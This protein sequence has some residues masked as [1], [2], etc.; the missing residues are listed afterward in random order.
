MDGLNEFWACFWRMSWQS[1]MLAVLVMGIDFLLRRRIS[2]GWRCALWLLVAARLVMPVLPASSVS[3]FNLFQNQVTPTALTPSRGQT[4]VTI[5]YGPISSP[6][7]ATPVKAQEQNW[8]WTALVATALWMAGALMLLGRRVRAERRTA[9]ML[10]AMAAFSEPRVLELVE[11][12]RLEIGLWRSVFV[13]SSNHVRT[14]AV[15]G[16]WRATLILPADISISDVE[17][18]MVVLHELAHVKRFDL[19]MDRVLGILRDLHWFNPAAWLLLRSWREEREMAC[20]EKVLNM[21]GMQ[22]RQQYGQLILELV[23]RVSALPRAAGAVG[24]FE[25]CA[26]LRKRLSMIGTLESSRY[27]RIAGC[28]LALVIGAAGLTD[29]R[30]ADATAPAKK[31]VVSPRPSNFEVTRVYEISDLIARSAVPP[32]F[33]DVPLLGTPPVAPLTAKQKLENRE[34]IMEG[35]AKAMHDAVP[36]ASWKDKGGKGSITAIPGQNQIIITQSADAQDKIAKLLATMRHDSG[37]QIN[38]NSYF[39]VLDNAQLSR[40]MNLAIDN[41]P[42]RTANSKPSALYLNEQQVKE[43][44]EIAQSDQSMIIGKPRVANFKSQ[45]AGIDAGSLSH[46]SVTPRVTVFNNQSAYVAIETQFN[47]V[48]GFIETNVGGKHAYKTQTS[49]ATAGDV[50]QVLS[51]ASPDRKYVTLNLHARQK[52]LVELKPAPWKNNPHLQFQEPV[53]DVHDDQA[54]VSIPNRTTLLLRLP[55]TVAETPG[56]SNWVMV[57]PEIVEAP[58]K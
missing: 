15:C 46:S 27:G 4:I 49:V 21:V 30:A 25:S 45:G 18:H 34:Q 31:V 57:R 22:Q 58:T 32:T 7:V 3:I 47:Y 19:Q 52:R 54:I 14:P 28:L 9:A 10:R 5:A 50:L 33:A 37:L 56:Q 12:C 51:T 2:A 17:L 26:D 48:S 38:I 36:G 11:R 44:L 53:V 55:D 40:R 29:A 16:F 41:A 1:G 20:D 35:I 24:L 8:N 13:K 43:V 39:V 6:G 42:L 23:E